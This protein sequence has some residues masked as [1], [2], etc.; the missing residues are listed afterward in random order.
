MRLLEKFT[1]SR[2]VTTPEGEHGA[3]ITRIRETCF[4]PR[5]VIDAFGADKIRLRLGKRP[6]LQSKVCT[7]DGQR[8]P[9]VG[10]CV[11]CSRVMLSLLQSAERFVWAPYRALHGGEVGT[12]RD[13]VGGF[14]TLFENPE[15]FCQCRIR[16]CIV[17]ATDLEMPQL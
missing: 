4:I 13:C 11:R 10:R 7:R 5:G 16:L 17:A 6:E 15:C 1:R 3:T 14:A 12:N 2:I 8:P 9:H